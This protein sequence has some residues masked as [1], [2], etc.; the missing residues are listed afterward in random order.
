MW[1]AGRRKTNK[2]KA[3]ATAQEAIDHG[4]ADAYTKAKNASRTAA[5]K[6]EFYNIQIGKMKEAPLFEDPTERKKKADE[7]RASVNA[8]KS[9]NMKKTAQMLKTIAGLV[10]EVRNEILKGDNCLEIL[11]TNTGKSAG[12]T[13][14]IIYIN[15]L[16]RVVNNALDH[17]DVKPYV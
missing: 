3:E 4:N 14:N 11:A 13:D 7:I 8:V 17:V 6:I 2:K 10:E 1:K 16:L 12:N 15:G 9:E 5:D